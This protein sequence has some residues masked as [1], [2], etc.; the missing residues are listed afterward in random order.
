M[1]SPPAMATWTWTNRP[2]VE[3]S[4]CCL[5]GH[6]KK[7]LKKLEKKRDK[8]I[9]FDTGQR[10]APRA[11]RRRLGVTLTVDDAHAYPYTITGRRAFF[12]WSS[13]GG[14]EE[15]LLFL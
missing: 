1:I 12:I 13:G 4:S 5:F 11:W 9:H 7:S 2:A 8:R 14:R 3:F 10:G 15:G 6:K